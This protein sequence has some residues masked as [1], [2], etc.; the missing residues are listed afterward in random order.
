M[1]AAEFWA[2]KGAGPDPKS[3][4]SISHKVVLGSQENA[5]R[6]SARRQSVTRRARF[7]VAGRHSLL[8]VGKIRGIAGWRKLIAGSL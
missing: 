7:V 4:G 3:F 2:V 1:W 6:I 8:P 5:R